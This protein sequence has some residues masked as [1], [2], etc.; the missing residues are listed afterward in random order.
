MRRKEKRLGEFLMEKGLITEKQ[1]IEALKEQ[2]RTNEFLG[3][4]LIKRKQIKERDLVKMLS[5]QYN[6]PMITLKN[7]YIDW[8]LVK[9]FSSALIL[10]HKCFPVR[11]DEWSITFAIT[12]PLDVWVLKKI[13]EE[14]MGRGIKLVLTTNDDIAT[15][16]RRYQAYR[17]ANI[18]RLFS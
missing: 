6:I 16:M 14:A 10:D 12:N 1:L 2:Q 9:R 4:I 18:D 15:V 5:E 17:K 8:D 3:S 13:E 11:K 7:R